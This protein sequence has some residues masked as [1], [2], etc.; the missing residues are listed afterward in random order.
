MEKKEWK[1]TYSECRDINKIIQPT[2]GQI[3]G[4]RK[5]LKEAEDKQL[6]NKQKREKLET[7]LLLMSDGTHAVPI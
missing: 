5:K 4:Q 1:K 3:E 6:S 7:E 2:N